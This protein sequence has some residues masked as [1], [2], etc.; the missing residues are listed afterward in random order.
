MLGCLK[1]FRFEQFPNHHRW[2][3][4]QLLIWAACWQ[5]TVVQY[6]GLPLTAHSS[7]SSSSSS[8][9]SSRPQRTKHTLPNHQKTT[10]N[11]YWSSLPFGET[12]RDTI[13]FFGQFSWFSEMCS[14]QQPQ[15]QIDLNQDG[16]PT[17][18]RRL[19]LILIHGQRFIWLECTGTSRRRIPAAPCLPFKEINVE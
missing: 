1:C 12:K 18:T 3:A 6:L 19:A 17:K 5:R 10:N 2:F 15:I 13:L 11:K 9:S 8:S 4:V 14:H 16:N 7:L